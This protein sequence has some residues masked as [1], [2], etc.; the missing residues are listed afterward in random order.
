MRLYIQSISEDRMLLRVDEAWPIPDDGKVCFLGKT[1]GAPFVMH[2]EIEDEDNTEE[3]AER[4][5][6]QRLPPGCCMEPRD[7]KDDLDF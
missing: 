2:L 1:Y 7:C 4:R 6:P 3:R 5:D